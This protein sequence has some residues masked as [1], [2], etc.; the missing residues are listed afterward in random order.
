MNTKIQRA[1]ISLSDKTGAVAFAKGLKD[2]KIEILSTGGTA[3]L[4]KDNGI[5][6]VEVGDYTG[7]PE[8]LDGRLK[9]LHPKIHGGILAMRDNP[10]HLEAMKASG[11]G[12]IDLLAVNLYPF[13]QT[14][15]QPGVSLEHA[16][17]NIDIGGPTMIRAAAKN[18]RDVAVLTDPDD[19]E[20]VL[21]E[22]RKDGEVSRETKFRLAQ[23]V[24]ILTARYDGAIANYL[25]GGRDGRWPEAFNYQGR[26]IQDLRYGENPHQKAA[27]YRDAGVGA[28]PNYGAAGADLAFAP[29]PCI[30]TAKQLHGKE[31]SYNNIMDLDAALEAAKEFEEPA[32][33]IIK[34]ATPC[35]V[36]HVV[37]AHGHA[38]L[39][40][41]FI[42][43][44]D[45]DPLSAF[46]GI[47][48]LNAVVDAETAKEIGRD[49]YECVIAHGFEK[50]AF[51]I[52]ASKKNIRLMEL[53]GWKDWKRE[54]RRDPAPHLRRV[55]GGLL[56][57]DR[58]LAS[59]NLKE[60]RVVTKR[61]PTAGEFEALA[62]AWKVVKHVKSNAI[63]Y[64]GPSPRPSPESGEGVILRTLGIGGGQVSRVDA[65]KTGVAKARSSL[66]EAVMAS[67]AFFP[68]RD[69]VDEAAKAGIAAI[70]QPG[71]SVKDAEVIQ[72]ADEHGIA[73]VFTGMRHFRH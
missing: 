20:P 60:A 13:E 10:A 9:T 51:D 39:R 19:Y 41:A 12:P 55:V 38:P 1:L 72:A 66:K 70:V 53:P 15:T 58:D 67:D 48:A 3:K 31:L 49:F 27:F 69:N 22:I 37:G 50:D 68:F 46:G 65:A 8:I 47:I 42:N 2:L 21:E 57:Q 24:F 14:V 28:T 34:H 45:C 40:E 4:L 29:E 44:R 33:V 61:V 30:A 18:W 7:Q 11:I 56:V 5:P 63:V 71:G 59:V 64:A 25:T 32:V 52:L 16:V 23:K 62:F 73:M 35:G 43:A 6:V 26:K 54:T 36:A 17:E